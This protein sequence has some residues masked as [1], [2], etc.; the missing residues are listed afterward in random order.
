MSPTPRPQK[1]GSEGGGFSGFEDLGSDESSAL[2]EDN[3]LLAEIGVEMIDM[4]MTYGAMALAQDWDNEKSIPSRM[5]VKRSCVTLLPKSWSL[6][7]LKLHLN[8]S[9]HL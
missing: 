3:E 4:M 9:S 8:L 6:V 1:E 2:F 7:K 5:H